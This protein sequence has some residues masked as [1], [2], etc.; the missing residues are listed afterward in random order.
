MAV[1]S[2]IGGHLTLSLAVLVTISGTLSSPHQSSVSSTGSLRHSLLA[3][4]L[5]SAG[6]NSYPIFEFAKPA[7]APFG[8]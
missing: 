6:P 2:R 5:Y 4:V 7:Q 8:Q 3:V 1:A